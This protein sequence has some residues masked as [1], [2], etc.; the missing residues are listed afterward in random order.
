MAEENPKDDARTEEQ[1]RDK[2]KPSFEQFDDLIA[3]LLAVPKEELDEKRVEYER[4]K[5]WRRT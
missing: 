4:A 5:E 2:E 3:K 1:G